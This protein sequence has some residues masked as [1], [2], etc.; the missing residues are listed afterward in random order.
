VKAV[1]W[2]AM[3]LTAIAVAGYAGTLLLAPELRP[4]FAAALLAQR[5]IAG[6]VHLAGG[7]IALVAGALQLSSRLRARFIDAHRWSGRLYLLAVMTG[8]VAALALAQHSSGGIAAQLGFGLLAVL[9]MGSAIA[10][11]RHV[12]Q[13]NIGQHRRWMLRSYALTF[14]AVTLRL[15]LPASQIAGFPMAIAYPVIAWLCWVPNLLA[16]E[17]YVRSQLLPGIPPTASRESPAG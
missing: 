5:P 14:A 10:A 13:G 12:R 1:I 17:W 7:A 3:T 4:P 15:Y 9:W 16:A 11:Y 6:F 2:L 8:G